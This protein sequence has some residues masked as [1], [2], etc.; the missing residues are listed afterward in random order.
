MAIL[1]MEGSETALKTKESHIRQRSIDMILFYQQRT[2]K[3]PSCM[4]FF[5]FTFIGI[6]VLEWSDVCFA[7][8]HKHLHFRRTTV[9]INLTKACVVPVSDILCVGKAEAF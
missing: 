7:S 6:L 3:R 4:F 1:K 8:T 9:K 5:L 2:F